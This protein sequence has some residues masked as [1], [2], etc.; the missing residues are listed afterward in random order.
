MDASRGGRSHMPIDPAA[1][2]GLPFGD[3]GCRELQEGKGFRGRSFPVSGANCSWPG[4]PAVLV[5][6]R[7]PKAEL[8]RTWAQPPS[9]ERATASRDAGLWKNHGDE[10]GPAENPGSPLGAP[11]ESWPW[12][13]T[14]GWETCVFD[15]VE[16]IS[17]AG[18]R[19]T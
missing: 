5:I 18:R 12:R 17:K 16:T 14:S 9:S 10:A 3:P 2:R 19:R 11:T 6:R 7:A 13:L 15:P 4:R 8:Q 1:P